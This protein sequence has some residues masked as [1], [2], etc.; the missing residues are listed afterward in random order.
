MHASRSKELLAQVKTRTFSNPASSST[1]ALPIPFVP[2][3]TT[4]VVSTGNCQSDELGFEAA[5]LLSSTMR[6]SNMK[7]NQPQR[8]IMLRGLSDIQINFLLL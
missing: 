2:P 8:I 1:T 3:V 4:A 6:L 5:N 7:Y